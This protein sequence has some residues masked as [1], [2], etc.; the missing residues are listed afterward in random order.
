MAFLSSAAA[1]SKV[2]TLKRVARVPAPAP[3][4]RY[5][6]PCVKF[7]TAVCFL[8]TTPTL[9]EQTSEIKFVQHSPGDILQY[10][11]VNNTFIDIIEGQNFQINLNVSFN[12]IIWYKGSSSFFRTTLAF[13]SEED[14]YLFPH[15]E[16]NFTVSHTGTLTMFNVSRDA[17][18]LYEVDILDANL[19]STR[20]HFHLRVYPEILPVFLKAEIIN[21]TAKECFVKVSCSFGPRYPDKENLQF[22][23]YRE[24]ETY[25][26]NN[27]LIR[28]PITQ[29]VDLIYCDNSHRLATEFDVLDLHTFCYDFPYPSTLTGKAKTVAAVLG[30][31][32]A[33]SLCLTLI[34]SCFFCRICSRPTIEDHPV[35]A[36]AHRQRRG[37]AEHL[38]F[39]TML[40]ICC[41]G[42]WA[43]NSNIPSAN[44]ILPVCFMSLACLLLFKA[45][46][47]SQTFLIVGA[48][49]CAT[50]GT[51]RAESVTY[52]EVKEGSRVELS[53]PENF[54]LPYGQT[55]RTAQWNRYPHTLSEGYVYGIFEPERVIIEFPSKPSHV[56]FFKNLSL[57]IDPIS[58]KDFGVY[59][60]QCDVS[61]ITLLTLYFNISIVPKIPEFEVNIT[62]VESNKNW[63]RV[64]VTC[65]ADNRPHFTT[66]FFYGTQT[67]ETQNAIIMQNKSDPGAEA[68][69]LVYTT[70]E[71]AARSI[72]IDSLCRKHGPP[73]EASLTNW[74]ALA[75]VAPLCFM[76]MALV[77]VKFL[78]PGCGYKWPLYALIVNKGADAALVNM[79]TAGGGGEDY[80]PYLIDLLIVVAVLAG[81][82]L[83]V[84]ILKFTFLCC[85]KCSELRE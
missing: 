70:F 35:M 26:G 40:A 4:W 48:A 56:R 20:L 73:A 62:K 42:A 21:S 84:G 9:S 57:I 44:H 23:F 61:P 33:V 53:V 82:S 25:M 76:I 11:A 14:V 46:K 31:S 83:F 51:A 74:V 77:I 7:L 10:A 2:D 43:A 32:A 3:T 1:T 36:P 13:I 28:H 58:T 27:L 80:S 50:V 30:I 47:P 38:V 22:M 52:M 29:P 54:L 24:N 5:L 81:L 75:A 63:C 68:L 34:I 12:L 41:P 69:C 45:K 64:F 15:A 55:Y 72:N 49:I 71:T 65:K 79:T 16:L 37:S 67:F 60:L 85:V 59:M 78:C 19:S 6:M 8:L 18:T 66:L 17:A 39:I